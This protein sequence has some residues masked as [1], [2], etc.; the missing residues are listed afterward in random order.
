M[1]TSADVLSSVANPPTPQ[2]TS[3]GSLD[4]LKQVASGTQA[5]EGPQATSNQSM[6][7][8]M[9]G[10]PSPSFSPEQKADFEAGKESGTKAGVTDAATMAVAGPVLS[11]VPEAA[12]PVARGIG[13]AAGTAVRLAR[14]PVGKAVLEYTLKAA[15]AGTGF[16]LAKKWL[17][18]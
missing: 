12:T 16:A 6:L 1:S 5:P 7:S 14:T 11:K 13:T 9:T 18:L 4:V 15:G 8:G 10:M 2:P 17:G 3:G